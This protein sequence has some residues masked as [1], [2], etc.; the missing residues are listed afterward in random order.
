MALI[1]L[2]ESQLDR[3]LLRVRMGYPSRT[4][5]KEIL[6]ESRGQPAAA[7]RAAVDSMQPGDGSG[8]CCC[9]CSRKPKKFAWMIPFS[10]TRWKSRNP[11]AK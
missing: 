1:L 5:E 8:R 3:F 9:V 2:P 4:S 6:R 7:G 10:I 11:R